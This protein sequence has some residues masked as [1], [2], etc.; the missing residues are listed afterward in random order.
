MAAETVPVVTTKSPDLLQALL[1]ADPELGTCP[2]AFRRLRGSFSVRRA[3]ARK[4]I[5]PRLR[6]FTIVVNYD[7][8]RHRQLTLPEYYHVHPALTRDHFPIA[9]TGSHEITMVEIFPDRTLTVASQRRLIRILQLRRPCLAE[10]RTALALF[11]RS[12]PVMALTTATRPE[13]DEQLIPSIHQVSS[14][15]LLNA[16]RTSN[17]WGQDY[18]LL[19][20]EI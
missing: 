15:R 1:Q 16:N 9:L 18:R 2:D 10:A 17:R 7:D 19:A 6:R 8:L 4:L 20:V 12:I 13:A 3:I 11:D 14:G 5:K